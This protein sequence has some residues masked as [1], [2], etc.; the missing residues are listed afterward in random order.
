MSQSGL[1]S[2]R[3]KALQSARNIMQTWEQE[4]AESE[5]KYAENGGEG[6]KIFALK[7][8][9]PETLFGDASVFRRRSCDLNAD[10]R[11]VI[12]S[13][14]DD[15]VPVSMIK[16]GQTVINNNEHGSDFGHKRSSETWGRR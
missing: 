3:T 16:Q 14:L 1:T 12:I 7:S 8:I 5:M 9:M 2:S 15:K 6:A 11:T 13:F 4:V 10:L